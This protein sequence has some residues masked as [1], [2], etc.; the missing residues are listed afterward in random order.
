VASVGMVDVFVLTQEALRKLQNS[1]PGLEAKLQEFCQQFVENE[2]L[3]VMAVD[4]RVMERLSCAG[5]LAMAVLDD[6][7]KVTGIALQG[8]IGDVS[9]G[10]IFF[11]IRISHKRHVRLL[12]GRKVLV[13]LLGGPP[14][15][16]LTTGVAGVVVAIYVQD[17]ATGDLASYLQYAVHIQFDQP[18]RDID[19][20]AV[21]SRG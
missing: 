20:A 5:K 12:L 1:F 15:S 21:V 11:T 7:G 6:Q 4:R 19:L 8:D 2:S 17:S 16:P 18:L 9:I 10:G 13:S 3:K 14:E